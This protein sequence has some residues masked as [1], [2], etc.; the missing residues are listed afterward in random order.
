[1]FLKSIREALKRSVGMS[2]RETDIAS[3]PDGTFNN[4]AA[5]KSGD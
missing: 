5:L 1:M 4:F 3:I 2:H